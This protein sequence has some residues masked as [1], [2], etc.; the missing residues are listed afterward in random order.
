MV[1]TMAVELVAVAALP[2]SPLA[3][4]GPG[5][6]GFLRRSAGIPPLSLT[7]SREGRGKKTNAPRCYWTRP[8]A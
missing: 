5:E 1:K 2:P 4:E 7:L 6:R 8:K 3:G